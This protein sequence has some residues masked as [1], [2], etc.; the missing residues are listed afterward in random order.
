MSRAKKGEAPLI[1]L[2]RTTDDYE[3]TNELIVKIGW[4][5]MHY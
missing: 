3:R 4:S 5:I 2:I 1:L